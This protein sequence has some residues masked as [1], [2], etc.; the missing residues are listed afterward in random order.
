MYKDKRMCYMKC[1]NIAVLT[2]ATGVVTEVLEGNLEP[3]QESIQQI[4]YE[5][6]LY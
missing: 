1:M 3:C 2:V 4:D 6:Q 5:R